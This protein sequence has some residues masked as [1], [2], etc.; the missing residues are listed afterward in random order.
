MTAIRIAR[1]L[2]PAETA[3]NE[4]AVRMLHLGAEVLAARTTG[5]FHPIEGQ[6]TIDRIGRA[7][8]MMFTAMREMADAHGGLRQVAADRQILGF[9]DEVPC[10]DIDT[11][12]GAQDIVV[13]IG[14]AA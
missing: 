5:E 10:P 2:A 13:P 4:A 3:M 6:D 12:R 1:K 11:P 8:T 9:G 7:T 14:V